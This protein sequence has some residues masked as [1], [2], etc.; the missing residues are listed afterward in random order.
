MSATT[1]L[2]AQ[3][4]RLNLSQVGAARLFGIDDRTMR[5]YCSGELPTPR[6]ITIAL[7]LLIRCKGCTDAKTIEGWF[8]DGL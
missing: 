7:G 8:N 4:D 1:T 6:A 5:R 3:L 2:Q